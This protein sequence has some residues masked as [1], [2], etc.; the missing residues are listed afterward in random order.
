MYTTRKA[1]P[2]DLPVLLA[3]EQGIVEAE[4]P[5]DTTLKEEKISYYDLLELVEEETSEVYVV[6]Y[7][8]EIIASGYVKI[9]EAKPFLKHKT[10]GFLGFMFVKDAHRGKG[11]NKLIINVLCDWCKAR[12]IHEIRLDVYD[13]NES[14]IKAYEK[15]GFEK[16]IT[17]MRLHMES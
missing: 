17:T 16:H 14:A 2:E 9:L 3:F 11:I 5:F 6:T 8:E 15:A 1:T 12:D 7:K 4:R 10:Y 13:Q